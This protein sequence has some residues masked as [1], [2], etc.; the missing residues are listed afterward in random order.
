MT[1][2]I[3]EQK[4]INGSKSQTWPFVL[5]WM[6]A[7]PAAYVL[8][9]IFKLNM[10]MEYYLYAAAGVSCAYMGF[11]F[12]ADAFANSKYPSGF[13][14]VENISRHKFIVFTWALYALLITASTYIFKNSSLVGVAE[15][16][17]AF[18]GLM[19]TE[20]VVGNKVNKVVINKKSDAEAD[21]ASK[22]VDSTE[23]K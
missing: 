9:S 4:K 12:A 19:S 17:I 2:T 5:V 16:T 15:K 20:Y 14:K 18:A 22:A 21:E 23:E 7:F 6:F 1:M 10:N 11:E 3:E 13:G 8:E